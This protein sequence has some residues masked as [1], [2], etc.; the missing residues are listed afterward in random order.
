M[1][2]S[3]NTGRVHIFLSNGTN[4]NTTSSQAIVGELAGNLFSNKIYAGDANQD[5]IIDLIIA[6]SGFDT[7]EYGKVYI[8]T[9]A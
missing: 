9:V 6:H 8:F 7:L 1:G 2:F 4:L 5:G 3:G